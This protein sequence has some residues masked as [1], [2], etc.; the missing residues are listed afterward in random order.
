MTD[1]LSH[2]LYLINPVMGLTQT[3]DFFLNAVLRQIVYRQLS[4]INY[5]QIN[6]EKKIFKKTED[7]V[8]L[9]FVLHDVSHLSSQFLS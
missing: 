1:S 2:F 4:T 3:E 6:S 8:L 7:V 9:S 5:Y